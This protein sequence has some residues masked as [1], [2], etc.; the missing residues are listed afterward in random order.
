MQLHSCEKRR[1]VVF[2][3]GDI[4]TSIDDSV[5][6]QLLYMDQ[7]RYSRV[8]RKGYANIRS[9]LLPAVKQN[10]L[11]RPELSLTH[12]TYARSTT[13]IRI[14]ESVTQVCKCLRYARGLSDGAA[15]FTKVEIKKE[16]CDFCS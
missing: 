2:A 8:W 7:N 13:T 12:F 1:L 3:T 15:S 11:K 6:R 5:N 4:P 9:L 14:A 10:L 16:K